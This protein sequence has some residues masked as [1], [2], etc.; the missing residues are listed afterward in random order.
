MFYTVK[1]KYTEVAGKTNIL[2]ELLYRSYSE[3]LKLKA[4]LGWQRG[5]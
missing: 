3:E 1:S 4:A 5:K 2:T